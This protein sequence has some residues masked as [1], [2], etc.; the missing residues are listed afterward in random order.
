MN[1]EFNIP[2]ASKTMLRGLVF[3]TNCSVLFL[4]SDFQINLEIAENQTPPPNPAFSAKNTTEIL[5]IEYNGFET[6]SEQSQPSTRTTTESITFPAL[7]VPMELRM[8][9]PLVRS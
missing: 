5:G 7:E 8:E 2:S 3:S 6:A 4:F 1:N 9:H